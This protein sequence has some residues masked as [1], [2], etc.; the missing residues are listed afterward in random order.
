MTTD[1]LAAVLDQFA[2]HREQVGALD[3]REARHFAS[4]AEQLTQLASMVTTVGQALRDG[5][6]ALGR[7]E[8]MEHAVDGLAARLGDD[9][10]PQS[11]PAPAWWT[12]TGAERQETIAQL[13]LW[14]KEVYRPGYG[15]LAVTLGPCWPAHDLCLYGLDILRQ[16][17]TALYAQPEAL[18]PALLSARA[19]YQARIVPAIAEQL[20]TETTA[21]GHEQARRQSPGYGRSLP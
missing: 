3:A 14:V 8:A 17:W 19:E 5:T 21:C 15:H 7:I 12:L 2:A 16:L 18:G 20:M 11:G 4:L 6:A 13:R 10:G 9:S 1:P